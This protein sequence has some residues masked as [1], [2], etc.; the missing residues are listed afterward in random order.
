M[1]LQ[2]VQAMTGEF[3]NT[4]GD[5]DVS[6][7][8]RFW[9]ILLAMVVLLLCLCLC[10]ACCIRGSRRK[11]KRH[12]KRADSWASSGDESDTASDMSE[13]EALAPKGSD[14]KHDLSHAQAS[15]LVAH[16]LSNPDAAAA[17]AAAAPVQ[18]SHLTPRA[19]ERGIDMQ[20]AQP[21]AQTVMEGLNTEQKG[22]LQMLRPKGLRQHTA[23]S[24]ASFML[25]SMTPPQLPD[26]P[27][28]VNALLGS[29][30]AVLAG[31]HVAERQP[32]SFDYGA[33]ASSSVPSQLQGFPWQ[34]HLPADNQ[35][36]PRILDSSWNPLAAVPAQVEETNPY[37]WCDVRMEGSKPAKV[38]WSDVRIDE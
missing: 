25:D 11:R 31:S 8:P 35:Q 1:M 10:L 36:P 2:H 37:T 12:H 13:N 9:P 16:D 27:S 19:N 22:R 38:A 34:D 7:L 21:S 29:E 33:G 14:G 17:A 30:A 4:I 26:S 24:A 5:L 32:P 28:F 6:D 3:I 15:K 18:R 20:M 23:D